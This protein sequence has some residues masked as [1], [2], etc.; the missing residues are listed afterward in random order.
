MKKKLLKNVS[1]VWRWFLGCFKRKQRVQ[2]LP[3]GYQE[4]QSAFIG[5][6][7]FGK[8]DENGKLVVI[9]PASPD[10][11]FVNPKSQPRRD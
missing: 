11:R 6:P 4:C 9:E 10:F 1:R 5:M 3:V 2:T 7:G 8:F